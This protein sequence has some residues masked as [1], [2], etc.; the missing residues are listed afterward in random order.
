[1]GFRRRLAVLMVLGVLLAPGVS[2]AQDLEVGS[3]PASPSFDGEFTDV[4]EYWTIAWDDA[5]QVTAYEADGYAEVLQ[6]SDEHWTVR[7]QGPIYDPLSEAGFVPGNA[8]TALI[9]LATSMGR[10]TTMLSP[11]GRPLQYLSAGRAWR[12]YEQENGEPVFLDVRALDDDGAFLYI[13]A[14][15]GGGT[16]AFNENY[17]RMLLLLE[18]IRLLRE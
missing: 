16:E 13:Q 17:Q 3:P 9:D 11:D 7:L 10:T 4:S 14:W 12:V 18:N 6:L 5:W 8:R 15:T 1:M 2:A